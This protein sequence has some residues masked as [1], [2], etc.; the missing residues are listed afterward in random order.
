MPLAVETT[1]IHDVN[2]SIAIST[3]WHHVHDTHLVIWNLL[4][5]L[6]ACPNIASYIAKLASYDLKI[7]VIPII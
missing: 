3:V 6:S 4:Y 7:S 1:P 5:L 2:I